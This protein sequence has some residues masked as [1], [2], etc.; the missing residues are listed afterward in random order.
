MNLDANTYITN[1]HATALTLTNGSV[2]NVKETS[3]LTTLTGSADS[4]VNGSI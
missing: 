4:V 1:T 2:W 3:E